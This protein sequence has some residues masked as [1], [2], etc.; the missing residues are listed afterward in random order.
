MNII[1]ELFVKLHIAREHMTSEYRLQKRLD[2]L[3]DKLLLLMDNSLDITKI[4]PA[5]GR[6]RIRQE[7]N[8][9]IMRI[10][11]AI[12]GQNGIKCWLNYGTLLGAVRHHGFVPWD[13]D[14][15]MS[16]LRQ[17][18]TQLL[19][20][21]RDTVGDSLMVFRGKDEIGGVEMGF[22]RIVEKESHFFVDLYPFDL[23]PGALNSSLIPTR[24]ESDYYSYFKTL[25]SDAR[26]NF[27]APELFVKID[28]WLADHSFGDGDIDGVVTGLD[29][30]FSDEKYIKIFKS[31]EYFPLATLV[32]EG[33]EFYVP[34]RPEAVLSTIYGDFCKFPK[35][36]NHATHEVK[37]DIPITRL[38]QIADEL[39]GLRFQ[40]E[41]ASL[42]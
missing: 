28:K 35:D 27:V 33:Y 2:S 9:T 5:M 29:Y 25:S 34:A 11:N 42:R 3:E 24:F 18:Y 26:R 19:D 6:L 20:A 40:I 38:R 23:I 37:A 32:F 22:S 41:N 15:D 30:V 31:F 36:A 17:D 4:K 39:D 21:V 1:K 10:L 16:V 8:L 13:D 12:A 14:A 7:I